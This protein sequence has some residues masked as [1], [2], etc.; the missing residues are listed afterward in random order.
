MGNICIICAIP[1]ETRQLLAKFPQKGCCKVAG[2]KSWQAA[3]AKHSITIIESG[4]GRENA[5]RA[6][7]AAFL[8]IKPD[9]VINGGFCGALT[10]DLQVGDIVT[11]N[12]IHILDKGVPG[13]TITVGA[14]L[15]DSALKGFA[16][17]DFI[18]A[19]SIL[20]KSEFL[21]SFP[22][23]TTA[24]VDMES[25]AVAAV[26]K[27]YGIPFIAV[28]AV[29]DGLDTDPSL[30]F[31]AVADQDFNIRLPAVISAVISRPSFLRQLFT[32]AKGARIAGKTL[33]TTLV[34]VLERL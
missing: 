10:A 24:V 8:N 11:A 34:T 14:S 26:C 18:S 33:A 6:A 23:L 1:Q 17:A 16:A 22:S 15:N 25:Y 32:L 31:R 5:T 30:L 21:K 20:G 9:Y 12:T 13:Q 4:I 3:S 29:S 7:T 27:E 28:R 19:D 2:F